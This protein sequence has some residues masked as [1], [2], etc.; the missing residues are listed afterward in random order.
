MPTTDKPTLDPDKYL[1]DCQRIYPEAIDEEYVRLSADLAYWSRQYEAALRNDLTADL[2]VSRAEARAD[3]KVRAEAK[4]KNEKITEGQVKAAVVLDADFM[5]AQDRSVEA[6]VAKA[7]AQNI[8]KA[9]GAKKEMLI[10]L[11]AGLRQEMEN[12]P[13][14]RARV[15]IDR[16][17]R[18]AG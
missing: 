17:Q 11:G 7:K 9:I 2:E 1:N 4:L 14:V 12:D 6:S 5:A 3:Q 15:A 16:E 10:S 13:V 8:L 18:K